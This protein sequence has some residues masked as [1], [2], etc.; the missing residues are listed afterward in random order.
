KGG[1]TKAGGTKAGGT[2][3]GG[4]KAA[5]TKAAG[6]KAA[7][8]KAAGTA[9]RS[10]PGG[11][12]VELGAPAAAPRPRT[13]PNEFPS[14]G[15]TAP[16]T[17]RPVPRRAPAPRPGTSAGPPV[18][19]RSYRS[20]AEARTARRLRRAVVILLVLGA[21]GFLI[22]GASRPVGPRLVPVSDPAAAKGSV[23]YGTATLSVKSTSRRASVCVL[24]AVTPAQHEQGLMGR[25]SIAPYA[26]MAFVFATPSRDPFW[27]K[28]TLIPLSVAWFDAS[29]R[30]EASTLM[31]PCPPV[32]KSCPLYGAGRSYALAVEVPAGRLGALGIGPGSTVQLGNVC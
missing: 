30:F 19:S 31:P 26:G 9:P 23:G 25:R 24:E 6:T 5:G 4:T 2:K 18:G 14:A 32:V 1:G 29:G 22:D 8:T 3:G 15:P 20:F 21:I 28:G 16:I 12:K 17:P 7:E 27:M 13:P 10:A 11:R